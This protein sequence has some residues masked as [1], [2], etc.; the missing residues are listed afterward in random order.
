MECSKTFNKLWP[1]ESERKVKS[2]FVEP[3]RWQS[4]WRMVLRNRTIE[5]LETR[6]CEPLS[7]YMLKTSRVEQQ[8]TND[9]L[10]LI[11]LHPRK[12][13]TGGF[14]KLASY[15]SKSQRQKHSS[16]LV[17]I[18]MQK[19]I[20]ESHTDPLTNIAN[21]RAF[22]E[23]LQEVWQSAIK[24]RRSIVLFSADIDYFK[25]INDHF[26]HNRGDEILIQVA[27]SLEKQLAR[28]HDVVARVGGEEF[29]MILPDTQPDGGKLMAYSAV[30]AIA[31]LNIPHPMSLTANRVT[32]G[33][34]LANRH[35]S[36]VA[37]GDIVNSTGFD[38]L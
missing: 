27:Q 21:R 14:V 20:K 38:S 11:E 22:D 3:A 25:M 33:N 37:L 17:N 18:K 34:D 15:Y 19:A 23:Y 6:L 4:D 7:Q 26:G 13:L 1:L 16:H 36:D 9:P 30:A 35:L 32:I 2:M 12:Q 5:L 28:D 29:A 31:K 10:F 24:D 8:H